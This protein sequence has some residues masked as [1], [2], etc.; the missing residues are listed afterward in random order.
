MRLANVVFD[1]G[2]QAIIQLCDVGRGV[3]ALI[4]M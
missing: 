1:C 4:E 3:F 2:E